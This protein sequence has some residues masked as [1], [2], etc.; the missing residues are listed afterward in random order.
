VKNFL[1]R[2]DAESSRILR[3]V[4]AQA[5]EDGLRAY[6]VGG[7]V[8]DLILKRK[9]LDLDVVI[10]GDAI[11]VARKFSS[12][13]AGK[14]IAYPQFGTATVFLPNGRAV[15]FASVR[16]ESYLHPGA[17][18]VVAKGNIKDDL[19]RRDFTV[20][21]MAIVIN[22]QC[23]G[24]LVDHYGGL[25]DI[26]SKRIRVLHDQSFVDDPTRILRAVRFEQRFQF[27]IEPATLC[28]LRQSLKNGAPATVKPQRYFE[29]FKK[30]LQELNVSK[31]LRRLSKLEALDF[32]GHPFKL[33]RRHMRLLRETSKILLWADKNL[34]D[35]PSQNRW[36]AFLMIIFDG[37]PSV[38]V[39]RILE[40]FSV[41]NVDR[42][43]MIGSLSSGKILAKLAL[44]LRKAFEAMRPLSVEELLF[45]RAK[46]L[47]AAARVRIEKHLL[48]WRH[49]KLQINGDDLKRLGIPSGKNYKIILDE[50]LCALV[51]GRCL[52]KFDQLA[53]AQG[54]VQHISR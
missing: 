18:P 40:K 46:T 37:M 4:G 34:T 54:L 36:S 28:L 10:E 27:R 6:A 23:F 49:L 12:D 52:S 11:T 8:R 35:C 13:C 15:D 29:E 41:A 51:E 9:V 16:Q 31:N 22:P 21:A 47:S 3:R 33:E 1:D 30:N 19:F 50:V 42:K 7:C 38:R 14:F 2:L 20:N 45:L 53:C 48:Q 43:K 39:V 5:D 32:L 26:K 24:Q 17:L 44:S 25:N